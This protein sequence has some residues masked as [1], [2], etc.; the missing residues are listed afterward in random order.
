MANWRPGAGNKGRSGNYFAA[1][2]GHK[3][4]L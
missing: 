2:D 3:C 1:S 4:N